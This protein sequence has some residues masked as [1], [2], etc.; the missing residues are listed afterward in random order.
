[1]NP[2]LSTL[3]EEVLQEFDEAF[4]ASGVLESY[5]AGDVK[6]FLSSVLLRIARASIGAVRDEELDFI[7]AIIDTD[8]TRR[9][10]YSSHERDENNR[11]EKAGSGKRWLTPTELA[12]QRRKSIASSRL[13]TEF[14]GDKG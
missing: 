6:R 12:I 1:M 10:G 3:T 14:L 4:Q 9:Y 5:T 11:R 8:K 13:A 7:Q 2:S